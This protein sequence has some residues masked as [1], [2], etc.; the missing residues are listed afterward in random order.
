MNNLFDLLVALVL[1]LFVG[2]LVVRHFRNLP[3]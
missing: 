2:A 3:R 1:A